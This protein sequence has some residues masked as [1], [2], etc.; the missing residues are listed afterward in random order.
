MTTNLSRLSDPNLQTST[1]K[2]ENSISP[3]FLK[4]SREPNTTRVTKQS[5]KR[6]DLVLLLPGGE[7]EDGDEENPSNEGNERHG[8]P[9]KLKRRRICRERKRKRREKQ[10]VRSL[11]GPTESIYGIAKGRTTVEQT[12][13]RRRNSKVIKVKAAI[14][15]LSRANPRRCD[16]IAPYGT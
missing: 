3:H 15:G 16:P 2:L 11:L 12:S 8:C 7:N 6:A 13:E 1:R 9:V 10:R 5:M 4:F 14:G